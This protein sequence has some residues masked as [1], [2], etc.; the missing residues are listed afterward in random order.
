[1]YEYHCARDLFLQWGVRWF[2]SSG[3]PEEQFLHVNFLLSAMSVL[4]MSEAVARQCVAVRSL[5]TVFL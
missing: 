5:V 4:Y 3:T 2:T 1:M